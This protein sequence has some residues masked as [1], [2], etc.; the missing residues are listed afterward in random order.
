MQP[1]ATTIINIPALS[2]VA[3]NTT[4]T[5]ER[6]AADW[7]HLTGADGKFYAAV[8]FHHLNRSVCSFTLYAQDFDADGDARARLP[9]KPFGAGST[10]NAVTVMADVTSTGAEDAMSAFTTTTINKPEVRAGDFYFV[11]LDLPVNNNMQILGVRV[12]YRPT[13]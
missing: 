12:V 7:G 10:F 3:G 1:P 5:P 9:R 13:C 2:F 6:N 4:A 11:E 8:P